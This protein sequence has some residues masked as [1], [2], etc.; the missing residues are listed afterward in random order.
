[1][2]KLKIGIS[3][4]L[5]RMGSELVKT[6][7]NNSKTEFSGGFEKEN[8]P[9]IGM[10]IGE[11][12]ELKTKLILTDDAEKVFKESEVV[13]DFTTVESTNKNLYLAKKYKK[14]MVIGT[15]ALTDETKKLLKKTSTYAPIVYSENMSIGVNVLL[16][17][18]Q[19][20]S[21]I[22]KAQDYD[23]EIFEK[24]HRY[25]IDAPSGTALALGKAIANGRG[26]NFDKIKNLNR[27]S[28][29]I[30]RLKGEIGFAVSRGGEISGEHYID[31]IGNDD[32]ISFAHKAKN[33]SIFAKGAIN[34]SL[35]IKNKKPG[36]YSFKEVLGI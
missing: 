7:E 36:L 20:A 16:D 19:K 25:K 30:K 10:T 33:R 6:I 1:M 22:F 18:I 28:K 27:T 11:I 4:C 21:K 2:K 5:G 17:L 9:K 13:V 34:A 35:W 12:L 24:H 23:I 14:P 26:E 3:G 31:F 32:E 8:N 29:K 15:T